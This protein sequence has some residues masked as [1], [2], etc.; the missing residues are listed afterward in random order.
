M[1]R[2]FSPGSI[3]SGAL[4]FGLLA[5]QAAV[6]IQVLPHLL[7]LLRTAP[8]LAFAGFLAV[9]LFP[10]AVVVIVHHVG[11]QLLDQY[12]RSGERTRSMLPRAESW[13][14]GALAWLVMYGTSILTRL[15]YLIVNPPPPED[16]AMSIVRHTIEEH[17]HLSH[18][19]SLYA[20]L[21][22][23][24]ATGFFELER[25]TRKA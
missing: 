9:V 7:D 18:A 21:W 13:W 5:A 20:L 25:R 2:A 6:A 4:A 3:L 14:A 24:T 23:V 11:H 19:V 17:A 15:T 16:D 12:D 8:R 1:R 22:I 10:A